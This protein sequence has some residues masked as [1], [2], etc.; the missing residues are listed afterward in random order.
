MQH[1]KKTKIRCR[2]EF[3]C[4][5]LSRPDPENLTDAMWFSDEAHFH[6]NNAIIKHIFRF[7]VSAKTNFDVESLLTVRK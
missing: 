1:F 2:L 5:I 7:L 4:S 6:L 3:A